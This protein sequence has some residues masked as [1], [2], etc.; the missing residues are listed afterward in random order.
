MRY[1]QQ[2]T[3]AE[4]N[5]IA[6]DDN[7]GHESSGTIVKVRNGITNLHVGQIAVVEPIIV[8]GTCYSCKRGRPSVCD[9][10]GWIGYNG[11]SG[12]MA[13]FVVVDKKKCSRDPRN[14][15]AQHRCFGRTPCGCLA[16]MHTLLSRQRS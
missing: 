13:D 2:P 9:K 3:P 15:S 10:L 14:P 6:I 12:G 11:F 8:D 16:I 1:E 4:V 5:R 7:K